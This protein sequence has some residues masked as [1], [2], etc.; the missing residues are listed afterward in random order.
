MLARRTCTTGPA[1]TSSDDPT[2]DPG[3]V[4][5]TLEKTL[6]TGLSALRSTEPHVCRQWVTVT[7]RG[8]DPSRHA[9]AS[10]QVIVAVPRTRNS[11]GTVW[12]P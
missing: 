5:P 7:G 4:A 12:L 8:T 10:S 6:F 2:V 3:D 9:A 11:T 1:S